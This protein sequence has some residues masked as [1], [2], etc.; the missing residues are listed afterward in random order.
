MTRTAF[1]LP[2]LDK[3][4][5][6]APLH[7]VAALLNRSAA[8]LLREPRNSNLPGELGKLCDLIRT[9]PDSPPRPVEG[10]LIPAFLGIIPT[11]GCNMSCVYCNFGGSAAKKAFMPP[12]LATAAIDWAAGQRAKA[13]ESTFHVQFFGGEPFIAQDLVEIVVHR[14]RYVTSQQGLMP[15]FDASTNGLFNERQCRFIGDYFDGIVLSLDG[16]PAFQDRYR[17]VAKGRPSSAIVERNARTLSE[18][19]LDLC[20]RLCV[21]QESVN[22]MERIARWM[23][24]SF[25]PSTINFETL[26]PGELATRAGL[27]PPDPYQFAVQAERVF[28]IAEAAG[29]KAVYAATET[30]TPRLS[31]CPVGQDVVIVSPEGRLSAC[32]LLPEEWQQ[33]G[34]DLDIGQLHSDRGATIFPVAL[35]KVRR[36]P[37]D[38]PRCERCFCQYTCAGG[39]HVNQPSNDGDRE[40]TDFCIQTRLITAG[41]LLQDLGF[42]NVHHELLRNRNAMERLAQNPCDA[43]NNAADQ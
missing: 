1:L 11:R 22:H 24:E 29:V 26:T 41:R 43:L 33:R 23:I 39:C 7:G 10:E 5:W 9:V 38:K 21:T 28:Q 25:D 12:E 36:L 3:W 32:Y 17:P 4:L 8:R 34:L 13:G 30:R 31:F 40:Y 27:A 14:A 42:E 6:Y 35:A 18:M 2:V 37:T 16:P 20:L 15:Y 19:P